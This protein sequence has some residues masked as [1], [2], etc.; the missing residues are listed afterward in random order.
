[1][2]ATSESRFWMMSTFSMGMVDVLVVVDVV[3]DVMA[4]VVEVDVEVMG[5]GRLPE[6]V[7]WRDS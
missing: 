3:T 2:E 7:T 4:V 5:I 6:L 1:M